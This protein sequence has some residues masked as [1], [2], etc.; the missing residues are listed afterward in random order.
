MVAVNIRTSDYDV[1]IDRRTEHGN[2]FILGRDGDR[3]EVCDK[4]RIWLWDR[5]KSGDL[6]LEKLAGLHGKRLGCHCYPLRCHGD[7]LSAAATWAH[8]ELQKPASE[9]W[10]SPARRALNSNQF[11]D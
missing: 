9:R 2:P 3:D 10:L 8:E 5:I 1:L 11:D 7:T 4:Y 6:S